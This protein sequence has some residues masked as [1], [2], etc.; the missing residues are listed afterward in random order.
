MKKNKIKGFVILGII[1][2][3]GTTSLVG[4]S[5]SKGKE[6]DNKS[7]SENFNKDGQL[8]VNEPIVVTALTQIDPLNK[9][10]NEMNILNR[11]D[12]GTNVDVQYECIAANVWEEKKNLI[13][14]S[15]DVPDIFFGGGLSNSDIAKYGSNGV[16]V[17]I[18]DLIDEYAPNIKKLFDENP[19]FKKQSTAADGH[20]YTLPYIDGFKP[21][22]T[23]NHLFINK[24]WLDNLGLEV[25][26]T[27]DE[28]TKVLKEFKEKDPNG[29]GQADEIPLSFRAKN[30]YNGD[31]SL[32]GSFGVTDGLEGVMVKDDKIVFTPAEEGYKEYIKWASSLYTE[33]L[34]DSEVFTQEQGQYV[35]KGK[36]DTLGAFLQFNSVTMTEPDKIED[37]IV[38]EPLKGPNGDQLWTNYVKDNRGA[39]FAMTSANENPEAT[40]RWVDQF[41]SQ[42]DD[43]AI[44]VHIGEFGVISEKDGEK[45][46]IINDDNNAKW[47]NCPGPYAPG[48]VSTDIYENKLQQ[49]PA[50][51]RKAGFYEAYKPFLGEQLP[52]LSFTKEELDKTAIMKTDII[53]YVD[54]MKAKWVTGQADVEA[55]WSAYVDRLNKMGLED[56]VK[57]YSDAYDRY[58]KQ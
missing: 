9:D 40:I 50:A 27:T 23:V 18:E 13:L 8:I 7:V 53:N 49:S 36:A 31:F 4:C 38:L 56:Y 37:W 58:K 3:L 33:G 1:L 42:Q 52:I 44:E 28:F 16:F 30:A 26:K 41:F 17:P 19:E 10:Y 34:M 45:I 11:F 12:E 24:K 22:D 29:N 47:E 20:I 46:N 43:K 51:I 14:A 2:A 55:D 5:S 39:K 6:D 48:I 54:E 57:I 35:A 25:P 15:G 32:S 21:E